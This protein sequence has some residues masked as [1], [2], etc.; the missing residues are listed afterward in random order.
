V[1]QCFWVSGRYKGHGI[2]RKLYDQC[3]AHCREAGYKGIVSVVSEKKKPFMVDKKV[4]THFGFRVCDEAD[5]YYQ[6]VVKHFEDSPI[7]PSFWGSAR[8]G[9][10]PGAKGLDFFYSPACPFNED[11]THIMAHIAED[12]GFPVRIKRLETREDLALLPNPWG[13]FSVFL[14]GEVL[15]AEVMTGPKFRAL[16]EG[17]LEQ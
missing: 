17:L 5:P 14:D 4:L 3:E 10:I 16:L 1:I 13:L 12:L 9:N 11:F 2:G 7:I 6:L 15:S 8:R